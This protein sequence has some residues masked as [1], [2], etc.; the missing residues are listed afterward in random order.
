MLDLEGSATELVMQHYEYLISD[1]EGQARLT[2]AAQRVF[3]DIHGSGQV[4]S[5]QQ[6]VQAKITQGMSKQELTISWLGDIGSH[7]NMS[8]QQYL[9]LYCQ[10][11]LAF[12]TQIFQTV[13]SSLSI[14]ACFISCYIY[15]YMLCFLF[16]M[17][18]V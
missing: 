16:T 6:K 18:Y 1:I 3:T 13:S 15:I 8:L 10:H 17:L 2:S 4:T 14:H 9:D 7:C 12:P 5:L 11:S